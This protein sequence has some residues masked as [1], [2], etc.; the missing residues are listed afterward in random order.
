MTAE[1]EISY[2]VRVW[3]TE[4]YRGKKVT[5][6]TVRWAVAGRPRK[7]PHRTAALAETFRSEL[8]TAMRKGEPFDVATGRPLSALRKQVPTTTWYDFACRYVDMK[9][10]AASPKHRK[11]IA[12]S[13]I[14]VTPAM[15]DVGLDAALAKK[16]RSALLNWGFN[17]RRGS[18]QQPVA[19]T[20]HLDW[21]AAHSR[22]VAELARPEV[23]RAAL[24]AIA[25]KLDGGRAAGRTVAVKRTNFA[26]ALSYAVEIGLLD[27]NPVRA[28]K[29]KAPKSVRVVDR[30]AVANPDQ[31]RRLL[32]TVAVTPRSGRKLVAFF[33]C[34][35]YSA[36][37]PEEA[38]NVRE[39]WLDL[40]AGDGWGW[41]TLERAAPETGRQWSDS[42]ARRD[43]RE[44]KHR[45]V[46]ETRRV[47][48][49]PELVEILRW[50]LKEYGTDDEGRLFRGEQGGVLAGV[51]YT[52][53]WDRA[54]AA[55]LTDEQY[56]SP[57]AR[58]PYD[59]RHAAV[60]TWLNG[61]VGPARVAEWAGHSVEVLLKIY[62]KCI[63]GEE[64]IALRRIGEALG[65]PSGSPAGPLPPPVAGAGLE[66]PD[67]G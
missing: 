65:R 4:V 56:A 10:K 57:L 49:P 26:S 50:H 14:T 48:V 38:V 11:S 63:D 34:L 13:L 17:A 12:E 22:L 47:P 30:R 5:S 19:V 54:R 35:Y 39:H 27:T 66:F 32:R 1:R 31:A 60:S 29:W 59:L 7:E 62:A 52:R 9:W 46:G 67:G 44:L 61:G 20:E 28:V 51:T 16:V 25:I 2:D 36:L 40:P 23:V 3:K 55:A 41:M 21:V 37:R 6:Y 24:E 64:G 45:A 53:L 58:R 15:L 42:D 8:L 18:D 43:E 33:A